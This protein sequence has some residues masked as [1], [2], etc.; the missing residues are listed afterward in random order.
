[1]KEGKSWCSWVSLLTCLS[2]TSIQCTGCFF[3]VSPH[4][5]WPVV[6]SAEAGP[7]AVIKMMK[8]GQEPELSHSGAF[9]PDWARQ[10]ERRGVR[11]G[12]R[13]RESDR[14]RERERGER[15]AHKGIWHFRHSHPA[16]QFNRCAYIKHDHFHIWTSAV[17]LWAKV[18]WVS[19]HF[20]L[21]ANFCFW[22]K[23]CK[24]WTLG[25]EACVDAVALGFLSMWLVMWVL[26]VLQQSKDNHQPQVTWCTV[27]WSEGLYKI[28]I[29]AWIHYL[30]K[31]SSL[32]FD[33]RAL[34]YFLV[35][36]ILDAILELE[37]NK[38][39]P[40]SSPLLY[41]YIILFPLGHM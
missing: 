9:S 12:A 8:E 40:L 39:W 14:E 20:M 27:M 17:P 25:T 21:E 38:N 3:R 26:V 37:W 28:L 15:A 4:R 35:L 36:E 11:E 18:K 22:H 29:L 24:E 13:V 6:Q 1:M 5:L 16:G 34:L 32:M 33:Q 19:F 31:W 30:H 10:N 23:C 7:E 2:F 41:D